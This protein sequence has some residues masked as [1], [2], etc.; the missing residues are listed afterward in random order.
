MVG[1]RE[2]GRPRVRV[3]LC[4][5]Q[6]LFRAGMKA[7]L[8]GELSLEVVGE[9][10]DGNAALEL[11][12]SLRPDVVLM[13][14]QMPVLD[15]VEATRRIT[16]RWKETKVVILT[17]YAEAELVARCLEAGVHG[18][19]LK[20]MAVAQLTCAVE[21]VARGGRYFSP[22]VMEKAFD[23]RGLPIGR[24]RTR[25]DLLTGRERE[26]LK[27]LVDGLSIREVAVRLARS[28]KTAEVHKYNLMRKLAVHDRA[29]LVKYAIAHRLVQMPMVDDLSEQGGRPKVGTTSDDGSGG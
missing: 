11:V 7:L 19:V 1:H 23:H 24:S 21:T 13:D 29:G 8:R 6:A 28:V 17:M 2:P 12:E 3:L 9:A 18:Y 25:Y 20:D 14:I 22:A 5:D 15:G 26:V 4:D 27:L 10:Q 16:E